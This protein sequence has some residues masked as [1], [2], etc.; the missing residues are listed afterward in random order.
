MK[1]TNLIFLFI[2][3]SCISQNNSELEYADKP[4]TS[5]RSNKTVK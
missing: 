5:I 1:F 3:K 4:N 2:L